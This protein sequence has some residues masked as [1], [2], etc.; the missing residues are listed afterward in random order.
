M[1]DAFTALLVMHGARAAIAGGML[2]IEEQVA[3]IERA[4]AENPGLA[5]DLAKTLIESA[6]RT[7]LTERRIGFDP[8]DDLPKLFK[9]ASQN[10]PFLP[11]SAIGEAEVR[12]SLAQTLNGLHTAIQGVCE[13]RN[14][15]GFAS[16]GADGPR[17]AMESVQ[18]LLAAETADAIIGFLHRVH[19]QDRPSPATLVLAYDNNPE[20][21][22]YVDEVHERVRIFDEEFEPSRVLFELAPEPYRVYLAEFQPEQEEEQGGTAGDGAAEAAT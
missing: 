6:C 3:G 13:L 9:T 10:L 2:H 19:R 17:P 22:D 4:V 11:M 12:N 20:F 5:F 1:T 15:C 16:H 18:A 14:Q 7:I 8:G 21:N